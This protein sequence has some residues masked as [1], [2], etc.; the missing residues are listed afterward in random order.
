MNRQSLIDKTIQKINLLPDSKIRE[1]NEYADFLLS[2]IDDHILLEGIGKLTSG[3]K[4]FEYL[5][6]EEDLYTEEDLKVKYK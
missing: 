3:S 6:D 4:S 2:R 1:I 5:L